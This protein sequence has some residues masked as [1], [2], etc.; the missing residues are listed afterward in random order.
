MILAKPA[1]QSRRRPQR[2]TEGTASTLVKHSLRARQRPPD[3][4]SVMDDC[5]SQH[6]AD[7]CQTSRA[8]AQ[9]VDGVDSVAATHR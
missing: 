2:L 1:V 4:S 6:R 5:A 9:E 3:H 7:R 8:V